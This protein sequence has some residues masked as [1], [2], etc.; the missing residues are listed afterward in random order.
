MVSGSF[1]LQQLESVVRDIETFD[2]ERACV[3]VKSAAP[4]LLRLGAHDPDVLHPA[5]AWQRFFVQQA[6]AKERQGCLFSTVS[7]LETAAFLAC[8]LGDEDQ[9]D[10]IIERASR[11]MAQTSAPRGSWSAGGAAAELVI[12]YGADGRHECLKDEARRTLARLKAEGRKVRAFPQ[13]GPC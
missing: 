3:T 7:L 13:A 2:I 6:E 8:W 9:R 12:M 1:T 10:A 11:I 5:R 4:F